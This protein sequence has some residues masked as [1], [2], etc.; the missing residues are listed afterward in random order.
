MRSE[1]SRAQSYSEQCV[2]NSNEVSHILL[3]VKLRAGR[4]KSADGATE[5]VRGPLA[6]LAWGEVDLNEIRFLGY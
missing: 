1:E 4:C 6:R 3:R 2:M 5:L